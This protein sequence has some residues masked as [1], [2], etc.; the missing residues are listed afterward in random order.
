MQ[1]K[2]DLR[3]LAVER[4]PPAASR[5]R[6]RRHLLSRYVLPGCLLA[7]FL[8]VL[9]WAL[10]DVLIPRTPVTVV[11]VHVS[12]A[13]SQQAG[14]PLFKAAGWV[15]PRPTLIAVAAL[16]P[17]VVDRLLVVEDQP[18]KAGEPVAM[19]VDDDARLT[20]ESAWADLQLREAE[21]KH[22]Q[23]TLAGARVRFNEPVHLEAELA[24][25]EA[26]LAGVESRLAS[27]PYRAESAEAQLRFAQSDYEGKSR[28][29]SVVAGRALGQSQSRLDGAKALAEQMKQEGVSLATEIAALEKRRA[30]LER[31]LSLR[32]EEKRQVEEAEAKLDAARA[33]V[34]Q[35]QVAVAQAELLRDR[36]TVRAPVDGRV[37]RLWAGP[38]ARLVPGTG[39]SGGRDGST[40]VSMYQPH[41]LQIRVDVRFDDLAQVRPGQPVLVESPAVAQAMEGEVLFL[42]SLADI[43]KNTLEV[44]VAIHAPPDVL[45]PDML[46]DATFLA[47]EQPESESAATNRERLFVPKQLVG[48]G[49][50]GPFVWVADRE[51]GVARQT[52]IATGRRGTSDLIEV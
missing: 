14:A 6:T 39:P 13:E 44:K 37:F 7:G 51:R 3:Q 45:K 40:V 49:D 43:Q 25:A 4:K 28:A 41:R 8:V 31:Q 23:A 50:E 47:P 26:E 27:L 34:T 29:G 12:R 38:G 36:M 15:E 21:Q 24:K 11:P 35:A 9:T 22:A 2:V 32:M 42:S 16:A 46:V 20:L 30:A 19:L 17:G 5:V 10:G 48:Q 52:S 33:Q 1:S 18:V